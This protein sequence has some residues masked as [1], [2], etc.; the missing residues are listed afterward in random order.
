MN[1]KI[2][3]EITRMVKENNGACATP[4]IVADRF[5]FYEGQLF[6]FDT[7][8]D[9]EYVPPVWNIEECEGF[10]KVS[11]PRHLYLIG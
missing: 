5:K 8:N 9:K 11:T 1:K 10:T 7:E 6:I 4:I 2:E 3:K